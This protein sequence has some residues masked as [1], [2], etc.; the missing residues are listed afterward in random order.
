MLLD[1]FAC[2]G[3]LNNAYTLQ[4][5]GTDDDMLWDDSEEDGNVRSDSDRRMKALTGW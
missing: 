2:T 5:D 1:S 3:F 4:M